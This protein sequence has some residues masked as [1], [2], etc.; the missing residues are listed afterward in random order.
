M[1]SLGRGK[2]ALKERYSPLQG[3]SH[4]KAEGPYAV[5]LETSGMESRTE[6]VHLPTY[7]PQWQA[8]LFGQAAFPGGST[9]VRDTWVAV[10]V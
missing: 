6:R 8:L 9:A 2:T 7:T 10:G 1:E 3:C 5:T 4:S